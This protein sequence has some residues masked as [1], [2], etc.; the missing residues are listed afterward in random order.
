MV[1]GLL[2]S[3]Q[4]DFKTLCGGGAVIVIVVLICCAGCGHGHAGVVVLSMLDS[5]GVVS[6]EQ[7]SSYESVVIQ[8]PMECDYIT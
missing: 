4:L 1:A 2:S 5:C 7:Y 8:V 6:G 3:L